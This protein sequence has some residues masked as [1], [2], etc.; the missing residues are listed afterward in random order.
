LALFASRLRRLAG[1]VGAAAIVL[2]SEALNEHRPGVLATAQHLAM[3]AVP[4][5]ATEALRTRRDYRSL[6]GERLAL[7][8]LTREQ[9]ACRR[10][11]DERLRIARDLHDVVAHT[12]ITINVQASVAG[13]LLD[14]RP[15]QA[16]HALAVI[17]DASRDALAELRAILGV[18]RD[19]DGALA[20]R[21]PAP[22]LDEIADLVELARDAGL[23]AHLAVTGARPVR[24]PEAVSRA[25]Y[26]I[27]Q[28]SLTNAARHTAGARVDVALSFAPDELAIAVENT[29]PSPV[30]PGVVRASANG[31][32]PGESAGVGILGM[33]ERAQALGGTLTTTASD[34]GFLVAARLPYCTG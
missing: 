5:L 4:I 16:R 11:Q 34:A 2:V 29:T 13:H 24:V 14:R 18:L 8:K 22:G 25:A 1:G 33:T 19:P 28:E 17:E 12:L 15:E 10:V 31:T 3:L 27:V 6:L 23:S 30:T 9:E 21:A 32:L 26:R 20:S 7:V